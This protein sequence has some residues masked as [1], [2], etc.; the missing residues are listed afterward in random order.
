MMAE[1]L[2]SLY[3]QLSTTEREILG[4]LVGVDSPG[5]SFNLILRETP[6]LHGRWTLAEAAQAYILTLAA[7]LDRADS[8]TQLPFK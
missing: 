3:E 1:K 8:H 5:P 7:Q 2:K 4:L 6:P